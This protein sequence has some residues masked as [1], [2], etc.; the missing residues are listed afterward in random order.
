MSN[1]AVDGQALEV[2]DKISI[3]LVGTNRE[4]LAKECER[5]PLHS[6]EKLIEVEGVYFRR[7]L[8]FQDSDPKYNGIILVPWDEEK[9]RRAVAYQQANPRVNGI[10]RVSSGSWSDAV[11]R[12]KKSFRKM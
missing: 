5:T 9:N 10:Y 1:F 2:C 4:D 8:V 6:E 3:F 11:D 7:A 12:L